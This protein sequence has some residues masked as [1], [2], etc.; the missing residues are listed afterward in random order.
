MF[1]FSKIKMRPSYTTNYKPS[2]TDA[3]IAQLE[4]HCGHSLPENYKEI[5]KNYNGAES[6]AKYF[7]VV[8]N[9]G[10][11]CERELHDFF[12]L[13]NNK[14]SPGNIWWNI[15]HFNE[16]MGPNTIPFANDG[17]N[18]VYFMKWVNDV[19]QVW[20]LAYLDIEEPESWLVMESFDELL[21]SLYVSE[22]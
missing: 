8:T 18:Q 14:N 6:G 4:N 19:P 5:L 15:E 1:D 22:D 9:E 13:D 10:V 2:A 16:Y 11:H 17:V 7:S 3:Q 20:F 21:E 12:Y